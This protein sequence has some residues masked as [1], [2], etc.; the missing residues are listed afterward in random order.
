MCDGTPTQRGPGGAAVL[1]ASFRRFAWP[2]PG[3]KGATMSTD[4]PA[5]TGPDEFARAF[6]HVQEILSTISMLRSLA[7]SFG[8]IDPSASDFREMVFSGFK[9][10]ATKLLNLVLGCRTVVGPVESELTRVAPAAVNVC[11][12][13]GAN[14]HSA[15][16]RLGDGVVSGILIPLGMD[17]SNL[18]QEYYERLGASRNKIADVPQSELNRLLALAE[19]EQTLARGAREGLRP[20]GPVSQLSAKVSGGLTRQ[21]DTKDDKTEKRKR[22]RRPMNTEAIACARLYK[23]DR[24]TD[25]TTTLKSVVEEYVDKNGGSVGSIMRTLADNPDQWKDCADTTQDDTKTTHPK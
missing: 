24:G 13:S 11:G 20:P 19:R 21:D 10:D 25:P 22:S 3:T 5:P 18:T 16:C 15:I 23:S 1:Q 14:A 4:Q 17:L 2:G 8:Q 6:E 9:T 7:G 12:A